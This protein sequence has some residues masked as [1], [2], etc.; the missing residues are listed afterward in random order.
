MSAPRT[1]IPILMYHQIAPAPAAGSPM[2]SLCVSPPAFARQ[3]R[4]LHRLGY[5]GLSM[6]ALLPYLRGE[7][8]GKVIGLT[9]DDGYLNNWEHALP[10]LSAL[11]F[12]ATCY[13]VSQRI[14]QCNAWD[15]P[16]GI[17]QVPLMDATHLRDWMAQGQEIGSHTQHHVRLNQVSDAQA[18]S[19]IAQ[20][21]VDLQTL[22]GV[23]IQQFCY[24]YGDL[25]ARHVAM[26]AQAGYTAATTTQRGRAVW[27]D[28]V[29]TLPRIPVVRST[30]LPQFLL[31]CCT[32]YEDR[33][34]A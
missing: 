1:S 22:L 13:V 8:H 30:S 29:Y 28:G 31:K 4:W 2:R 5:Q 16:L 3:M 27:A 9:F 20:S 26:V 21:R 15:A 7:R 25:D 14:G 23:E 19:E 12:S 34:R 17:A 32:P 6:S 10:V 24:P 33:K 18:E 11:G